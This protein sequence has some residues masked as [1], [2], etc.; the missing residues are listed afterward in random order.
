MNSAVLSLHV[1]VSGSRSP[2]EEEE[3]EE[4]EEK[5][6]VWTGCGDGEKLE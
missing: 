3:E 2:R 5:G 6:T 1:I 4:E